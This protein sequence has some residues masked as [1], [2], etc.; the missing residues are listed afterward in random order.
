MQS[1]IKLSLGYIYIYVTIGSINCR[2]Q[3][4]KFMFTL[5]QHALTRLLV[6]DQ[7][8]GKPLISI[9]NSISLLRN[10]FFLTFQEISRLAMLFKLKD[11]KIVF[12]YQQ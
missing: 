9:T 5:F 11:I 8:K 3:M 10:F 12:Q 2:C 7:L 1:L 4:A 6:S